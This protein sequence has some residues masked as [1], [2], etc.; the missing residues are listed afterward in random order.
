MLEF[1]EFSEFAALGIL[2]L[3]QFF[4]PEIPAI[5]SSRNWAC[6][7]LFT[8][9]FPEFS[10][11]QALGTGNQAGF[12]TPELMEFPGFPEFLEFSALKTGNGAL[13]SC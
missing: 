10:E 7:G 9:E 2:R 8:L 4:H 5:P 11:F 12:L 1:P 13:F 6:S 3:G